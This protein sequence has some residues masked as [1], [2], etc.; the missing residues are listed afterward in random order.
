MEVHVEF[1]QARNT[2]HLS[3]CTAVQFGG[4]FGVSLPSLPSFPAATL[5]RRPG[6]QGLFL[7]ISTG[8]RRLYFYRRTVPLE[9]MTLGPLLTSQLNC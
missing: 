2:A 4:N 8:S 7:I 6:F 5:G 3:V 9:T 1:L